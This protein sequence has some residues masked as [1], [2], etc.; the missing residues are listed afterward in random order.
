MKCRLFSKL[1]KEAMIYYG[2]HVYDTEV[3]IGKEY[4]II[5]GSVLKRIKEFC[6]C[7]CFSYE[8][9]WELGINNIVLLKT[10]GWHIQSQRFK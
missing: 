3:L 4:D 6:T 9:L 5:N 10:E 8:A 7:R 1:N 2:N